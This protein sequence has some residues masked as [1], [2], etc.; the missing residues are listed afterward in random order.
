MQ[1]R[2]PLYTL[3]I[4]MYVQFMSDINCHGNGNDGRSI[5]FSPLYF[6]ALLNL[7]KIKKILELIAIIIAHFSVDI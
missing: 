5:T 1:C 3:Y 7:L 6:F 4:Y 2:G